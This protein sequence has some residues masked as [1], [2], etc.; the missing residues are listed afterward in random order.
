M[1]II[2]P[3]I[4]LS[5]LKDCITKTR[6]PLP[7]GIRSQYA[8]SVKAVSIDDFSDYLAQCD[9]FSSK[10]PPQELSRFKTDMKSNHSIYIHKPYIW[11][12]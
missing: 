8:K 7:N 1:L 6:Q 3:K 12:L 5:H 4:A 10:N 9:W 11:L 2:A